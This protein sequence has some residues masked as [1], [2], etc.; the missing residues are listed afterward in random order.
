MENLYYN[1]AF[2]LTYFQIF[3][4]MYCCFHSQGRRRDRDDRSVRSEQTEG[5]SNDKDDFD[6]EEWD[7][8]QKVT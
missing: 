4:K 3:L 6:K 5:D 1:H 8:E 7:E 2:L